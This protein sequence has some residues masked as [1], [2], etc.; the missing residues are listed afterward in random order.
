M[1]AIT[2]AT[3]HGDDPEGAHRHDRV[4]EEVVDAGAHTSD[5][6]GLDPEEDEPRVVDGGEG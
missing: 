3:H 2:A 5:G 1:L 4:R 6:G